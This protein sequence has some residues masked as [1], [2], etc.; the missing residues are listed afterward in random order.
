M[1]WKKIE[2]KD[3]KF[4][5]ESEGSFAIQFLKSILKISSVAKEFYASQI[6]TPIEDGIQI[7][8]KQLNSLLLSPT[9]R[10]RYQLNGRINGI[11]ISHE[12]L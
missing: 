9:G 12:V 2:L 5:V 8:R 7:I 4:E 3:A 6:Q 10:R 1:N 11:T